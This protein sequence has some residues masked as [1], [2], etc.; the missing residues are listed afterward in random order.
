MSSDQPRIEGRTAYVQTVAEA[1]AASDLPNI[2]D[3]VIE[4]N[5]ERIRMQKILR[6]MR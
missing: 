5:M 1:F 3:V 6:A 2:D 4:D